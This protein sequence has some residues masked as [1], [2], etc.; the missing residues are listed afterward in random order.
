M[1][2]T[3]ISVENLSK[4]YRLGLIGRDTLTDD[5]K[6]WW[7]KV[8]GKPNPLQ[9]I[10]E[11]D[12]ANLQGETLWALKD[13][14]LQ[15][16][17]GEVLGIIGRNG[18]GKSPLLKI[19]SKVTAPT[20]GEVKIKGRIASLL[21]VGTGFHPELTGRENI[22]LNG[23]ILGMNKTE[24]SRKIDEIVEFSGV[25]QFIYT[26]V[27]RYSS[28]M[29]VRLAFAV[30]AHMEPEILVVDEVLAVGDAE[31]QK[32]CLG[33][34]EAETKEGRTILIVSHNMGLINDLCTRAIL[35]KNGSVIADGSTIDVTREYLSSAGKKQASVE[36]EP[37]AREAY[38]RGLTLY[39]DSGEPSASFD[40]RKPIFLHMQ[41]SVK[42]RVP[43]LQA[44]I[45]LFNSYGYRIFYHSSGYANPPIDIEKVGNYD[46]SVRLPGN[47]LPAGSYNINAALHVPNIIL[48]DKHEHVLMFDVEETGSNRY[49]FNSHSIGVVLVDLEWV[50]HGYS[51]IG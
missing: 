34:M 10:G 13:I 29:Y 3:V 49:D 48:C 24:I 15:V 35:L 17:Q 31:F 20:S 5:L 33:R 11:L 44:S 6:V 16:Q 42:Q 40:I 43:G 47:L 4:A 30:A 1:S 46:I 26:P 45:S 18:A 50:K 7:A 37:T 23:A 25:E 32:K 22:Y 41:F 21:E 2:N 8:R 51:Q 12:Q 39:S 14:N 9:K 28:G 36:F 27:K 38:F 19:L